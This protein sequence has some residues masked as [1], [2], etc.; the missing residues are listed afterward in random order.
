M[1]DEAGYSLV[2][3]LVAIMLLSIA[4]IPMVG[5][6]DMGLRT[7]TQSS[8]YD[9]ARTLANARMEELRSLPFA[10]ETVAVDSLV[11]K[12]TPVNEPEPPPGSTPGTH[13]CNDPQFPDCTITT[14]YVNEARSGDEDYVA[15]ANAR[16]F[17]VRV[18]VTVRWN[19]G[20]FTT[21]GLVARET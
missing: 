4:I 6:F 8:T 7:A 20:N 13:G 15:A 14:T 17:W 10:N 12:Y 3:L 9:E 11:E 2:E 21:T 16:T 5:M 18:V 19:G 1:R